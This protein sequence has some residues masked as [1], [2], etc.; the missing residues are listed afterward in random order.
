MREIRMTE[1]T[2]IEVDSIWKCKYCNKP[3][4]NPTDRVDVIDIRTH[5]INY[6]YCQ[7]HKCMHAHL[8]EFYSKYDPKL[9]NHICYENG[10][11][12]KE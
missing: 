5:R 12:E 3:L 2:Q 7:T 9:P 8:N 10:C 6:V 1:F 4:P 11:L